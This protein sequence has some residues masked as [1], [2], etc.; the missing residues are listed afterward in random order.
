MQKKKLFLL[1]GL[2]LLLLCATI[3]CAKI[4]TIEYYEDAF[5]TSFDWDIPITVSA[6]IE[7]DQLASLT[8]DE[9]RLLHQP[10]VDIANSISLELGVNI[11][12]GTIDCYFIT[13]DD[14]LYVIANISLAEHEVRLRELGEQLR[15]MTYANKVFE[16]ILKSDYAHILV[17]LIDVFD[18]GVIDP[19]EA[20]YH[21]QHN[22]I[23]SFFEDILYT[24]SN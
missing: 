7:T 21:I 9:I 23:A 17:A 11:E 4:N 10:Y 15:R 14:I 6:G 3:S 5:Y 8:D 24:I 13:R 22:G 16:V 19:I 2:L 1:L 12:I 18:H 20:Y